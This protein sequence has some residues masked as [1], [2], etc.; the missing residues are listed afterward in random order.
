MDEIFWIKF[1]AMRKTCIFSPTL[2]ALRDALYVLFSSATDAPMRGCSACA[3]F[4]PPPSPS[5]LPPA[6]YRNHSEPY[7]AAPAHCITNHV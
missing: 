6:S 3:P 4:S 7:A 1:P 5:T 2:S